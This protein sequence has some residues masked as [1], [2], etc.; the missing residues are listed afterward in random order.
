M[1]PYIFFIL[2]FIFSWPA[3]ASVTITIP[4][5]AGGA[6][7]RLG[8]L[9]Q[10]WLENDLKQSVTVEYRLGNGGD[11]ASAAVATS[12]K[13]GV[14]LLVHSSAFT[15]RN[16]M[17][18]ERYNWQHDL[19]PVT[20]IGSSPLI[21]ISNKKNINLAQH[22]DQS[23]QLLNIGSSGINTATAIHGEMFARLYPNCVNV[24][25]F[26][27]SAEVMQSLIGGHIDLG[28]VFVTDAV[29]LIN[30]GI[31]FP[32]A[33]ASRKRLPELPGVQTLNEAKIN[34]DWFEPSMFV[35]AN[36]SADKSL[37]N[38]VQLS[39]ERMLVQNKSQLESIGIIPE[40][41]TQQQLTSQLHLE[42]NRFHREPINSI[43]RVQ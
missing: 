14:N 27:G 8:R 29:S 23:D 17:P 10:T 4:F 12:R 9:V 19:V 21:L 18:N 34:I 16:S 7:D 1:K 26:K 28:F 39:L 2:F 11:I 42:I 3:A 20:Y 37:L 22:C 5:S 30:N 31:V 32:V 33:V 6:N 25:P 40:I 41:K 15:I 24:I 36:S 35:L 38:T 13:T 43:L